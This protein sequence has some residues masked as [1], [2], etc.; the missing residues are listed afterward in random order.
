MGFNTSIKMQETGVFYNN[1]KWVAS[2][3]AVA[4]CV[5]YFCFSYGFERVDF[6]SL[7][8]LYSFLFLCFG[9]L[10]FTQKNQFLRLAAIGVLMRIILLFSFPHLSQDFYRF[11]WDGQ[12]ILNGINPYLYTPNSLLEHATIPLN[13]GGALLQGMGELS[14][15]NFSNYPPV[16]QF[17]FLAA[18]FFGGSS[19]L[20]NVVALRIQLILA[21][22]GV[23]WLGT[24]ILHKLQLS[25]HFIF[26]YFLNPFIIIEL[27]GNLHFEGLMM[28]YFIASLYLLMQKKIILASVLLGA[29]ISVKLLPLLLLPLFF[30]QLRGSRLI[31]FY[32]ITLVTFCLSFL[33][34]IEIQVFNNYTQTIGLWFNQFEFNASFYY[35][36]RKIGYALSGYNQIGIIGQF[37]PLIVVLV[38]L[39]FA[40]LRSNKTFTQLL[41]NMLFVLTI[42]FLLSTTVH[43]WYLTSL[44]LL[45][46]FTPFRFPIIWSYL[47]FLSYHAYRYPIF[48][49]NTAFLILQYGLVFGWI[50]WE[51][52]NKKP[53][54][55][56]KPL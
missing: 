3:L 11:I 17:S 30:Q 50:I 56:N 7:W 25:P 33:P 41:T 49:E 26:L 24:K 23:L 14:A 47:I 48:Q 28:C 8:L 43:P 2:L 39:G 52:I 38:V 5:G 16:N 37:I 1:N 10:Y 53:F 55:K 20:G 34:F 44:V 22:I 45:A 46:P 36:A 6:W 18:S 32:S 31:L 9:G 12:L 15:N 54:R 29:A 19:I 40:F 51:L 21:D 27:T 4:S 35:I 42:Y 13:N